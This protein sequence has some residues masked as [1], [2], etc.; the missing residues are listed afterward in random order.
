MASVRVR[1]VTEL[2]KVSTI[3]SFN[4]LRVFFGSSFV[5]LASAPKEWGDDHLFHSFCRPDPG[6]LSDMA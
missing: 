4:R 1:A 3:P 5:S 2:M 6:T